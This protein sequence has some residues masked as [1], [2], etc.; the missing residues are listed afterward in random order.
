MKIQ[1]WEILKTVFDVYLA[2]PNGLKKEV[3]ENLHHLYHCFL[4]EIGSKPFWH[5]FVER[6]R[7]QHLSM[8]LWQSELSIV[9][10]LPVSSLLYPLTK[11]HALLSVQLQCD[12]LLHTE[13]YRLITFVR[14]KLEQ[15]GVLK[16]INVKF[17]TLNPDKC[18]SIE[19]PPGLYF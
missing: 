4:L 2:S 12:P 5:H 17:Q 16:K 7:L 8:E 10:E 13:I 15:F 3:L 9:L 11:L 6:L 18:E 19:V 1:V 14:L